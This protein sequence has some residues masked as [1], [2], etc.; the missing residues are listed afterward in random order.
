MR[1]IKD[2]A[3]M[4]L[5]VGLMACVFV[6]IIRLFPNRYLVT[7]ELSGSSERGLLVT[8]T[9]VVT[10][11]RGEGFSEETINFICATEKTNRTQFP[12]FTNCVILNVFKLEE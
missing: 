11:N 5:V 3:F 1:T 7:Y 8:S 6:F 2:F 12:P 9:S 4:L 10:L